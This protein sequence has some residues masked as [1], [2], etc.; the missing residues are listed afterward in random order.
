MISGQ[1]LVGIIENLAENHKI[2]K[3]IIDFIIKNRLA[4]DLLDQYEAQKEA[5][6][7]QIS[8]A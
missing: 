1:V 8:L 2:R 4:M 6:N 5:T 7:A 3:V